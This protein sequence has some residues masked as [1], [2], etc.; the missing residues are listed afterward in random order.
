MTGVKGHFEQGRWVE[1][2]ELIPAPTVTPTPIDA[3]INSA[4]TAI[5]DAMDDIANVTRDLV[6]SEE[7]KKYIEKTV[8][9]STTQV[10]KSIQ[11]LLARAKSDLERSMKSL[12]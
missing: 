7:G 1:D 6:T 10:Q 9:D 11:D 5:L 2:K 12:K 8:A 3:R 4:T